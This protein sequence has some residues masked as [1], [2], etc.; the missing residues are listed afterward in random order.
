MRTMTRVI[1][2]AGLGFALLLGTAGVATA[3]TCT[4]SGNVICVGGGTVTT[5]QNPS[6]P[7]I[8]IAGVTSGTSL[9]TSD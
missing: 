1:T 2:A 4:P 6:D 5:E 8:G 9:S 7:I 3:A